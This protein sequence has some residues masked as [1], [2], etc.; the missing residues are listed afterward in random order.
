MDKLQEQINK[1]Y[2]QMSKQEKIEYLQESIEF[3]RKTAH[4][5]MYMERHFAT[6]LQESI[7]DAVTSQDGTVTADNE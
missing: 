4:F 5:H 7:A 6:Q 1:T 3:H 2:E